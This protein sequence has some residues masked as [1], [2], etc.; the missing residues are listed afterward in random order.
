[1]SIKSPILRAALKASAEVR[2][3]VGNV[4]IDN[5]LGE[6]TDAY[7]AF[8]TDEAA[9]VEVAYIESTF[10]EGGHINCD[11]REPGQNLE[12]ARL[13]KLLTKYATPALRSAFKK[14]YPNT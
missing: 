12:H 10:R 14:A 11:E 7:N 2:Y 5:G 13:K 6:G 8:W 3:T 1:M 9:F 4:S